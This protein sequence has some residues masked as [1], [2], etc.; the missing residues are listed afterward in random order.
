[1]KQF[2]VILLLLFI[3]CSPK[4]ISESDALRDANW[5][6]SGFLERSGLDSGQF[7]GPEE[8]AVGN[9]KYAFEWQY[10]SDL[11]VT[12]LVS[13]ESNGRST[14][15]VNDEHGALRYKGEQLK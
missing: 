5:K 1:M 15:S 7:D 8:T 6:F 13:I 2:F 4:E 14:L 3:G 10:T 12:V 9:A 11:R